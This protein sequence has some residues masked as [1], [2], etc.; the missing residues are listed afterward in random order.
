MTSTHWKRLSTLVIGLALVHCARCLPELLKIGGLFGDGDEDP[1]IEN[2]FRYAVYRINHNRKLLADTK[3]T[4]DIQSLPINDGFAA[5]KKVC[6]QIEQNTIAVFGPRATNLAG[7]VTSL[8]ASLQVPHI[9]IRSDALDSLYTPAHALTVNLYPGME[10]L[11]R[12]YT[13][14][15]T[16]YGWTEVL[17]IY[18][19]RHGLNRVHKV[20][21]GDFR[22]RAE[23]LVRF[24]EPD[25]MRAVLK[26]AKE[27]KWRR[28]L[29]DLPV[30][31]TTIFMKMALQEGM[32]DPYHHYIITNLD[33]ESIDMEDF[34]HNYVNL[35]GFRL[36]D[37]GD[38]Q[39]RKI[40]HDMEIYE[41]Q[42]DLS[43]LNTTGYLSIPVNGLLL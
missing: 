16:Y 2:A 36:V 18:G 33:V 37:P 35:T 21:R 1:S 26:E 13:D 42:T 43:L 28:M 40:I 30:D 7:F 5:S 32:I 10:Q 25:T 8:C 20:L 3:L 4:Y 9:E 19:V 22:T 14:V 15:I 29:V 24:V 27:K 39:V 31:D 34:R 41:M 38:P 6:Y 11:G 17:V 23:I 12:A